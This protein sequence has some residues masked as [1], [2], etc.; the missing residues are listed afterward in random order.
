[1]A[2]GDFQYLDISTIQSNGAKK[3]NV[4]TGS[5][6]SIAVAPAATLYFLAPF[7]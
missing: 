6:A 5:P 3:Y 4:A 2:L 1:M 7:D